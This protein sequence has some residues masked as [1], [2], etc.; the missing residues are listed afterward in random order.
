M[1]CNYQA[2]E[3]VPRV[4]GRPDASELPVVEEMVRVLGW[5]LLF[6]ETAQRSSARQRSH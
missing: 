1:G 3:P 4:A 6:R 2:A 5:A